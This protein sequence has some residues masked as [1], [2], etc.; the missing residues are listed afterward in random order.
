MP[1]VPDCATE[2]VAFRTSKDDFEPIRDLQIRD[3]PV[4]TK[5]TRR[6]RRETEEERRRPW[7]AFSPGLIWGMA[8][9]LIG[10]GLTAYCISRNWFFEW[11]LVLLIFGTVGVVRGLMGRSED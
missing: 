3:E 7:I 5:K 2:D 4:K 6:P 11:P 8:F 9:M 10:G 1:G